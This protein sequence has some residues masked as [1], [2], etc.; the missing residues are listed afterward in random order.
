MSDG[1]IHVR[2]A[3]GI[4]DWYLNHQGRGESAGDDERVDR[5]P[6]TWLDRVTG[7]SAPRGQRAAV[8]SDNRRPGDA[9]DQLRGQRR[10]RNVPSP[11]APLPKL[12]RQPRSATSDEALA[13][14]AAEIQA[15][16]S[17]TL[18]YAE[19]ARRLQ[20]LGWQIT[21]A[22]LRRAMRATNTDL[23]VVPGRPKGKTPSPRPLRRM[24][25]SPGRDADTRDRNAS[26]GIPI[27][28][29][30]KPSLPDIVPVE[31]ERR[32]D[33]AAAIEAM[34]NILRTSLWKVARPAARTAW[35]SSRPASLKTVSTGRSDRELARAVALMQGKSKRKL[36]DGEVVQKLRASGWQVTKADLQRIRRARS[37]KSETRGRKCSGETGPARPG[38]G[39]RAS[40]QVT[41]DNSICEG[42]GVAVSANGYCRCS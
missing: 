37:I 18:S 35:L 16:S 33:D 11:R 12:S 8:G 39:R 5:G 30:L 21:K 25:S 14:R 1:P 32:S 34:V 19:V 17:Q 28:R 31:T 27:A 38:A 9:R 2:G 40:T 29:V 22:D 36:S 13:R 24:A 10:V 3:A 6:D 26:T 23:A 41:I 20:A 15:K 4:N 42:C 7:P